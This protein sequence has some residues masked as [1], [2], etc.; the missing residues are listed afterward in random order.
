MAVSAPSARSGTAKLAAVTFAAVFVAELGDKTQIAALGFAA[1]SPGYRWIVFAAAA[2]ALV[3][4]SLI[5]V[6]VGD[7]LARFLKPRTL[8]TLAGIIFLV[9]AAVFAVQFFASEAPGEAA[10]AA[11]P[12]SRAP[13]EMFLFTFAAI[14]VAELGDKTQLATMSLAAGNRHG[15][16]A[17]FVGAAVALTATSALACLAGRL[18]G[19][20][21]DPRIMK[22]AAAVLFAVLGVVFLA[23]R[24]EKGK[25][26]F[27]WLAE[28]IEKLYADEACSQCVRLARFLEHIEAIGNKP[29]NERIAELQRGRGS[30]SQEACGRDCPIDA[31]HE[32]WH[33][34]FDHADASPLKKG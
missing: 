3:L 18:V 12:V 9:C 28:Q 1:N 24:A 26:E 17:V 27:A 15:R 14:F 7:L 25:A 10:E 34:R 11:A 32:Q 22:L 4:S 33:Q 30:C 8:S 29:V 16:W 21:L 13:W 31:L 20:Y 19:Q 23:G 6:L 2:A 5:G